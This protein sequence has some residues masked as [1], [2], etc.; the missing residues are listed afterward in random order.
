MEGPQP[1]AITPLPRHHKEEHET[2][3]EVLVRKAAEGVCVRLLIWDDATSFDLGFY[4]SDGLMATHD[5]ESV[6]YFKDTDVMM[7]IVPCNSV[8]YRYLDT[9]PYYPVENP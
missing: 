4:K 9:T 8:G 6:K 3:G 2:L 7:E 5:E 1:P